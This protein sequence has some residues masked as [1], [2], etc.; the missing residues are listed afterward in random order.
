MPES[1]ATGTAPDVTAAEHGPEPLRT[2]DLEGVEILRA[3]GPVHGIGSPPE[4]D[5]IT[6]AQLEEMARAFHELRE[7]LR[8]PV[9]LGHSS[10]QAI[11]RDAKLLSSDGAP[12]AGWLD[13][14][15]VAGDSLIADLRR[16]PKMVADLVRVGAFR[17][18]SVAFR[19]HKGRNGKDYPYV[20]RHLGLLG[21]KLPAVSGLNDWIRLYQ[22]GGDEPTAG[23]GR[24]HV[25][26]FGGDEGSEPRF[27]EAP[28]APESVPDDGGAMPETAAPPTPG[29]A[30]TPPAAPSAPPADPTPPAAAAPPAPTTAPTEPAASAPTNGGTNEPRRVDDA[31]ARELGLEPGA[32]EADV[33]AKVREL[34]QTGP[35]QLSV[36]EYDSLVRK[37]EAGE[38]AA[39]A[40]YERER[41]DR[42]DQAIRDG[43][44]TPAQRDEWRAFYDQSPELVVKQLGSMQPNPA[45]TREYG[46]DGGRTPDEAQQKAEDAGFDA[47]W[48]GFGGISAEVSS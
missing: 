40:L 25:V 13:N 42:V 21:A 45:F 31:L 43:K 6:V 26:M 12:A 15:R 38:R 39:R 16:V 18:R 23:D 41:D 34:Q 20:I 48:K 28:A 1:A 8:P 37:A 46:S 24:L 47:F 22:D 11:L 9:V 29:A 30:T 3:G 44:L 7:E 2:E 14:V 10:E 5:Q 27:Y 33:L 4:G 17:T 36:A 19:P 35:R 32:T